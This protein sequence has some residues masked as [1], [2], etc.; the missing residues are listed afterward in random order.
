MAFLDPILNPVLQPLLNASPFLGILLLA[1]V[2]SLIITFA[3]KLFTNQD[4]MKALKEE[5][6]AYQKRMKELRS[7]P[8]EMMKVQKEAMK[9]NMEYMKMS[10]KP[11]LITMIPLLLIFGWMTA[12]LAYE[13]IYPGA[14]FSVTATFAE[15]IDGQAELFLEGEGVKLLSDAKQEINSGLIWNLEAQKNG[16][17]ILT[18]KT[19]NSE[20]SKKL[21]VTD[22]LKYEEPISMFQHSDIE[23]I[24]INYNKLRPA[25]PDF[26]LF[27]WQPGWLGMYIIFSIVFSMGLRKLLKIY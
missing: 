16:D 12:H 11:T 1:F 6:K 5:Q 23:Q 3:Y 20:E 17:Q 26:S 25:G 24:K 22:E 10:F 19:E 4:K 18:I 15:G 8:D 9:K 21:L 27:G 13:P 7:T 14:R 2:L